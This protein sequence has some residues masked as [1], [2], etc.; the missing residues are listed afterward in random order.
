MTNIRLET[1]S[2]RNSFDFR[3]KILSA[4]PSRKVCV[5]R[6]WFGNVVMLLSVNAW[7][8]VILSR[9]I[10]RRFFGW[11][12]MRIFRLTRVESSL[13]WSIWTECLC[14]SP[15]SRDTVSSFTIK[16]SR[17]MDAVNFLAFVQPW[18]FCGDFYLSW[19]GM[20]SF[21]ASLFGGNLCRLFVQCWMRLCVHL[22]LLG[23][24]T[25]F[26]HVVYSFFA[27]CAAF[28]YVYRFSTRCEAF[29]YVYSFFLH[30]LQCGNS[31]WIRSWGLL[32]FILSARAAC[33]SPSE[34][35]GGYVVGLDRAILPSGVVLLCTMLLCG[36]YINIGYEGY[37]GCNYDILD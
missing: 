21:S 2:W 31:R 33:N 11:S 30:G 3:L 13:V 20:T 36:S 34:F 29:A 25:Y 32:Q 12:I 5:K 16:S 24:F 27:R 35:F 19:I 15:S 22:S 37:F 23:T 14:M 17:L 1:V 26:A 10:S 28:A 4:S 9:R 7:E 18:S 6:Y 8:I